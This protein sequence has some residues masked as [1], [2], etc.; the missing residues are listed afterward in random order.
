MRSSRYRRTACIPPFLPLW[1]EG[2]E[3]FG[4]TRLSR[5]VTLGARR[6]T[7]QEFTLQQH[8]SSAERARDE[9]DL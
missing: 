1:I 8:L 7:G 3:Q 2:G 5:R 4:H 9:P 6:S